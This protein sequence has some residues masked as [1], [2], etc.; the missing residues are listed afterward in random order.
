LGFVVKTFWEEKTPFQ[1]TRSFFVPFFFLFGCGEAALGL[2][3]NIF[4][5][6]MVPGSSGAWPGHSATMRG[7]SAPLP[8]PVKQQR[9]P[10]MATVRVISIPSPVIL[11]SEQ[12]I[13]WPVGHDYACGTRL[14]S[15]A[16]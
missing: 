10:R 11:E 9:T 13:S 15:H 3:G 7:S 14:L 8:R 1:L 6:P 4:S 5:A 12:A 16:F 2:D